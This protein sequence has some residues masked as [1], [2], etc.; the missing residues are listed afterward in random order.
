MT[1]YKLIIAEDQND[2]ARKASQTIASYIHLAFDEKERAQIAL[3]GGSTP[4]KTYSLL[5]QEHLPWDRVDL[6]LGDERWVAQGDYSSNAGMIHR[7]LLSFGPGSACKFH[8]VPT[9]ELSI[10]TESAKAF[11]EL[12]QKICIGNP[13]VFD[14]ILLRLFQQLT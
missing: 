1:K 10:P 4:E 11:S 7:T 13:P 14:L 9:V 12:L 3:S 8:N 6:F 5:G 2:L